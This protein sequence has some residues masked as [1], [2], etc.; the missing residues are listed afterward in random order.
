MS[1][2]R[3]MLQMTYVLEAFL[4]FRKQEGRNVRDNLKG[5]PNHRLVDVQAIAMHA[6]ATVATTNQPNNLTLYKYR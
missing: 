4:V 3:R 6:L 2:P 1:R 5:Q